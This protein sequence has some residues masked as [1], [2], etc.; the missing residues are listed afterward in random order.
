M[1]NLEIG[2]QYNLDNKFKAMARLHQSKYR[3]EVLRV[4]FDGYGNRLNG[5][6]AQALLNYY[7]RLNCRQVLRDRYPKYSKKRDADMLR[8]EHIPF[9]L[10]APLEM[11]R[12]LASDVISHAFDIDCIDVDFIGFEYAPE[13]KERY[14]NDG[15]AFDTYIKIKTPKG[16]LCG[17]G[18]EVKYTE[19]EYPI[20]KREAVN[21][22]NRNS[23]Y[24]ERARKSNCFSN[25]EDK[26]FGSD[27]LRQ[28]WRNHLLGISMVLNGDIDEFYSITLFPNGND[29]FHNIL[30]K[31]RFLLK[32]E[33]RHYV[34]GCTFEKYISK[35]GGSSDFEQWKKWLER[36]YVVIS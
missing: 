6:D 19:R 22:D 5:K 7:D 14:L 15:T 8:S 12:Q 2:D 21:V 33:V 27:L 23:L 3:A 31:Y 25:P 9:N 10:L 16:K 11:E 29:H 30:Q 24:W 17:I 4:G 28:V 26:I 18:I 34:F 1:E 13:P 32:D 20:G 36:R 35:I